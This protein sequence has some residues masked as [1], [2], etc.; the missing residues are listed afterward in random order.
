MR[1][2]ARVLTKC[3]DCFAQKK[4]EGFFMFQVAPPED[5]ASIP[6]SIKHRIP[7]EE[8]QNIKNN[9]SQVH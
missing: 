8:Y 3:H 1:T 2:L 7:K 9:L 4:N 5:D 6:E